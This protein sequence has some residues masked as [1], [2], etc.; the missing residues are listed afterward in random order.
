VSTSRWFRAAR[1]PVATAKRRL[2]RLAEAHRLPLG[3]TARIRRLLRQSLANQRSVL[4]L[5]PVGAV[6]QALPRAVLDVVGWSPHDLHVT[7]VSDAMGPRSLPRRWPCVIVVQPHTL[8][9]QILAA[10]AACLPGGL[11]AVVGAGVSAAAQPP[12]TTVLSSVCSGDVELL[13]LRV[14]E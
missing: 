3:R 14:T 6:R 11:V 8:G 2:D 10:G 12:G 1:H 7:I 9:E 4:V 13:L 5:G